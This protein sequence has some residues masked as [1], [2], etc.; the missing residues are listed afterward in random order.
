MSHCATETSELAKFK[1]AT[2]RIVILRKVLAW[3]SKRIEN[4]ESIQPHV[5]EMTSSWEPSDCREKVTTSS[6]QPGVFLR[7]KPGS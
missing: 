5:A 1:E 7:L 6:L 3:M 4:P 2:L